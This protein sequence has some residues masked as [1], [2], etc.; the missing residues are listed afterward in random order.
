MIATI[1]VITP[2]TATGI[3]QTKDTGTVDVHIDEIDS[4]CRVVCYSGLRMGIESLMLMM[5]ISELKLIRKNIN[6]QLRERVAHD[7]RD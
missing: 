5:P 4:E 7:I 2:S 3:L 1:K 6:K